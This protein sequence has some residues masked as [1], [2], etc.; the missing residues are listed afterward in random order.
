MRYLRQLVRRLVNVFIDGRGEDRLN[1]EIEEHIA[2]QTEENIHA[3]MLPTEARRQAILKFG[4][5]EAIKETYR[6]QAR[7][8]IVETALAD[9]K[10]GL[11]ILRKSPGFTAVAVLTL[12]L[13][14]GANTTI[15]SVFNAVLLRP[16]PYP[17]ADRIVAVG[18]RFSN[19][20]EADS[21]TIPQLLFIRNNASRVF[22]AVAGYRGA[23]AAQLKYDNRTGWVNAGAITDQFF[24]VLGIEPAL[25]RGINSQEMQRGGPASAVITDALWRRQFS[26]DPAIVGKPILLDEK[27]YTIV[28]VLPPDFQWVEQPADVFTSMELGHSLS[29]EGLNTGLIARLKPGVS[30]SQARAQIALLY[31]QLPNREPGWLGLSVTSYQR[32]IVGD[33]R[34]SLMI[35]FGAVSLL[36]LIAC[37]NVANLILARS[38]A[39]TGEMAVRLAVGASNARLL[40]QFLTESLLMAFIGA[41]AGLLTSYW[42]VHTFTSSIPWDLHV[43]PSSIRV[44]VNVLA[45]T[46]SITLLTTILFGVA[47]FWQTTRMDVSE[48]LKQV[49]RATGGVVQNRL[50]GALVTGEVALSLALV[51]AA[52]LLAQTLYNLRSEK[53]GFDPAN[54]KIMTTPFP[55]MKPVST[56]RLWNFERDLLGRIE[57]L[58]GVVS[59]AVISVA[60]LHGQGNLPAQVAGLN[61]EHHSFG[62]TEVR[63]IS[64]RY[65]ETMHIPMLAG[66]GIQE[67]D[68]NGTLPVAVINGGLARRWFGN[69]SP[70][71]RDVVLGEYLGRELFKP[72]VPRQI[73][74]VVGDVKG[75]VLKRPAPPMVYIPAAQSEI[76]MSDSTDWVIR[77]APGV[78]IDGEVQAAVKAMD[79]SQRVFDLRSM[80]DVVANSMSGQSFDALLIGAFA[81]AALLLASIGI[82]GVLSLY[83][84]QRMQEIGVRMA[85]GAAPQ[86]VLRLVLRQGLV[87]SAGGVVVGIGAALG[88]SRFLKGLLYGVHPIAFLPYVTGSLLLMIFA[89]LASYIPARRATKVDPI[90]ALRH[91]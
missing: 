45:F 85:L 63:M 34:P 68:Q 83:V 79:S 57:T 91:E 3:G 86:Q 29:N 39:R 27:Q 80:A 19:G 7:L 54:V 77:T 61:D 65:F 11:R 20:E 13:G 73:V 44:D 60:P 82:Y 14:I 1:S 50:R 43:Q 6:E 56:V 58:P 36:L 9:V 17:S 15:F 69:E 24:W 87:L 2:L 41:C 16:L 89:L 33:I 10:Y 46:F 84:N 32:S 49:S 78:K 59:A 53:L 4:A 8:P 26:A 21:V 88:L 74:G 55:R 23:G 64:S 5:V 76:F 22:D 81:A 12:A 72:T 35:L 51:I 30:L 31:P 90:I 18:I 37:V 71:G 40:R 25:G 28:G 38:N 70:I 47:S 75:M 62:G 67:N 52:A 42:A 66:R 48:T